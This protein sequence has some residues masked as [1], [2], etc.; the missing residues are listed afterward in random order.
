MKIKR[1]KEILI[2][3]QSEKA[4]LSEAYSILDNIYDSCEDYG[5]IESLSKLAKDSLNDLLEDAAV[6]GG[7]P[8]GEVNVRILM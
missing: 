1:S 3:T 8:H 5:E 6:E 2:L 4:I 7:E